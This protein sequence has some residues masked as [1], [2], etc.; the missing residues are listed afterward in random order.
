MRFP[1]RVGLAA[2]VVLVGL[3]SAVEAAPLAVDLSVERAPGAEDC[4]DRDGLARIVERL[5]GTG[6]RVRP[7]GDLHADVAFSRVASIYEATLRFAGAK[8]GERALT[9]TGPTCTALGR[10]V[11]ITITLLLDDEAP[12][13]APAPPPVA[14]KE[15][16]SEG[17]VVL[18]AG[19]GLGL[20]GGPAP[21]A[22]L[23][24]GVRLRRRLWLE[25]DGDYVAP[26]A[27]AFAGGDVDVSLAFARLRACGVLTRDGA[28]ILAAVCGEGA[29]GV[30]TGQG[31]GYATADGTARLPWAAAGGGVRAR[32]RLRGRW[33]LDVAAD[34]LAPLRTSTFSVANRGV[35]Y[36]STT[37][38]VMLQLGVGVVIW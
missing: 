1:P 19:A 9:D 24:F 31:R 33:S 35:A 11:G 18:A 14:S 28:A 22:G 25:L 37:P 7:G 3:A 16:F 5:T 8:Q 32:R 17:F 15:A 27:T 23:A 26:R 38:G 2:A 30:L 4:P 6:G 10:A 12:L 29:G 34:V 36:R 20:V 21:T 13:V